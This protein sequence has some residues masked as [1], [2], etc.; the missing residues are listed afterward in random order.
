MLATLRGFDGH[1]EQP[2]VRQGSRLAE[3]DDVDAGQALD[4]LEGNCASLG[5]EAVMIERARASSAR[6][7]A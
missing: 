7:R 6:A 4:Y 1:H 2:V 5:H 3:A